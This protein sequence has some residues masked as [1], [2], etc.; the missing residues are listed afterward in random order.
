MWDEMP[1]VY[2]ASAVA[3]FPIRNAASAL[4]NCSWAYV[5][6]GILDLSEKMNRLGRPAPDP[7]PVLAG[8]PEKLLGCCSESS[9][10]KPT[11]LGS[12]PRYR[13]SREGDNIRVIRGSNTPPNCVPFIRLSTNRVCR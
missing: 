5:I 8:Y 11:T 1:V 4:M 3:W 7:A 10:P 9:A 2:A 12:S 6:R 13:P